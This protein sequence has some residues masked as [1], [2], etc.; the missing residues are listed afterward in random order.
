[1]IHPSIPSCTAFLLNIESWDCC[2]LATFNASK[3]LAQ[4][5][6][7][8]YL[9]VPQNWAQALP[10]RAVQIGSIFK[11][12]L[13]FFQYTNTHAH[14]KPSLPYLW[15]EEP[16]LQPVQ[17]VLSNWAMSLY[18]QGNHPLLM[19]KWTLHQTS[20]SGVKRGRE[21]KT[22]F[23]RLMQLKRSHTWALV[24]KTPSSSAEQIPFIPLMVGT[25]CLLWFVM[26]WPPSLVFSP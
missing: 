15:A 20:W 18:T 3:T 21:R 13:L 12:F 16:W 4:I 10:K 8:Q 2:H 5:C 11:C 9:L 1:M 22:F 7:F 14:T 25:M 17:T 26:L 19:K 6:C 24:G 23:E